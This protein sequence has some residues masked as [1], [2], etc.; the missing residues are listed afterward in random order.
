M[1]LWVV[2]AGRHGEY[3]ALA[4]QRGVVTVGWPLLGDLSGVASRE[5]LDRRVRSAHPDEKPGTLAQWT[6]QLWAFLQRVAVGDL[7]ALPL[8]RRSAIAIGRVTGPYAYRADAPEDA[9]HARPVQ[10]LRTDIPRTDFDP[11][12][13]YSMGSVLTVFRVSRNAAEARVTAILEGA[14]KP[15]AVVA[16]GDEAVDGA[17]PFDLK[18]YAEDQLT[19]FLNRKFKGHHLATLVGAVLRA[20]GYTVDVS[21]PGA[22]GG[23]DILAGKG[24]MGFD[25][26]RLAVQVKSEAKPADVSV[27]REL[28]GVMPRFGATQGLVVSWSGFKESVPREARQL[29]FSIRLW[30]AGDLVAAIQANYERLPAEIQAQL[31]LKRMWVLAEDDGSEQ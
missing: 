2:R 9:R 27:L 17:A 11:D 25:P 15:A 1:T 19:D 14:A 31:P 12:I 3:E 20:E 16:A 8:K 18:Q 30:D 7:V 23:V 4:L 21:T 24:P 6:G 26:P 29:F 10:W 13:L 28:Q 22:D 5:D